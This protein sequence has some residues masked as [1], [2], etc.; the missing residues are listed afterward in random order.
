MFL[1][2]LDYLH[3]RLEH[4]GE[5]SVKATTKANIWLAWLGLV[6]S[7]EELSRDI[8]LQI[9]ACHEKESKVRETLVVANKRLS[10]LEAAI[11]SHGGQA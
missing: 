1:E 2:T 11:K 3:Q 8:R 5:R 4:L 10:Q 9:T 7:P 6:P